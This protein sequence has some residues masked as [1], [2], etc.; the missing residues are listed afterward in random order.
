MAFTVMLNEAQA[1]FL[2]DACEAALAA[3]PPEVRSDIDF[4]FLPAMFRDLPVQ[5]AESPGTLHGFCL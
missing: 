2:A 1:V 5:E 4:E 3:A